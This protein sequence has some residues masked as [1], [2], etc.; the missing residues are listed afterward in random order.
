MAR[1]GSNETDSKEAE[2]YMPAGAA[3]KFSKQRILG[4]GKYRKS[5]YDVVNALLSDEKNYSL[6]EVDE[7]LAQ[8]KKGEA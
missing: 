3:D 8:F 6:A 1:M 4:S 5:D 7:K 2:V